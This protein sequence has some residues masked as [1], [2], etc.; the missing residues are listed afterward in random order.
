MGIAMDGTHQGRQASLRQTRRLGL[1]GGMSWP[2]TGL[3]Y[4][5]LNRAIEAR[6]GPHHSFDGVIWNLNYATLLAAAQADDWSRIETMI[7]E[8]AAGLARADCDVLVLTAVTAHLFVDAVV[9]AAGRPVVHILDGAGQELDRL[10]VGRAGVLGT[11]ATC[12][13]RFLA[14]HLG[15]DGRTLL[16][17]E[18]ERQREIDT[19]IQ[20]VLTADAGRAAGSDVLRN[21]AMHLRDRGAEAVVLAC[22]E[23]PL[24]LPVSDI[25]VPMVDSVALHIEDICNSIVSDIH[26]G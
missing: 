11:S 22:T 1:V 10:A 21:A 13:A 4:Q 2:S 5:R 19:L 3:Y 9:E 23:L 18:P 14:D 26:A 8:A 15:A 24:L 16:L 7:R 25:G 20:D 6:C 12:G 17:L